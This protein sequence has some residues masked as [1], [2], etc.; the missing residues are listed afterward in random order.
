[1]MPMA[2]TFMCPRCTHEQRI[3]DERIGKD[4]PCKICH[5]LIKTA[6][7]SDKPKG[8]LAGAEKDAQQEGIKASSQTVS[9]GKKPDG[10]HEKRPAPRGVRAKET[11]S[12]GGLALVL[13]GAGVFFLLA[14]LCGGGI[15]AYFMFRSDGRADDQIAHND[16]PVVQEKDANQRRDEKPDNF[17]Q[18]GPQPGPRPGPDV[19]PPFKEPKPFPFP[20]QLD[21]L[22]HNNPNHIDR[23]IEQLRGPAPQRGQALAWLNQANPNNV[24]RGDV[25][26]L[27]DSMMDEQLTLP[28]GNDSFFNPYFRWATKDCV[29]SLIRVVDHQS[30]AVWHNRYRHEAMKLLAQ[31]KD[32]RGAEPIAKR[33]SGIFDGQSPYEALIEMGPVAESAVL[34]YFNDP[35]GRKREAARRILQA[36]KTRNE[37]LLNACL[38]DLDGPD[39]NRRGGALQWF[40]KSPVDAKRQPEVARAIN[41]CLDHPDCLRNGDLVATLQNWATT[42]N[43]PKLAQI[44]D[45][46]RFG[47]AVAIRILGKLR[48][49]E[50][51][52]AV[53]RSMGNFFNQQEARNALKECGSTA[54][55]AVIEAMNATSDGRARMEYVR[56]LGEIGTRKLG[57]AALQQLASRF[58][59]DRFLNQVIQQSLKAINDR[60]K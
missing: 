21:N 16:I 32:A 6:P 2:I 15:G 24:R 28:L 1:M 34:R 60:G 53:A 4:V 10:E 47:N 33:L 5:H 59:Q 44:L 7:P 13:V 27:L 17:P 12:F 22:D 18:P 19:I 57:G 55:P 14:L 45:Q 30:T 51:I 11:A 26:K 39:A 23:V 46:S 9:I 37:V 29:P 25:A 56:L 20:P 50:G 58:Q 3:E 49:P 42:E 31:F 38:T 8:K 41:K 40:A 35:D 48:D 36:Y 43:V 54:E 52:K